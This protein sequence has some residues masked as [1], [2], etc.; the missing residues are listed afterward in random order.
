MQDQASA[1][2]V[3]RLGPRIALASLLLG[4]A[5]SLACAVLTIRYG[6]RWLTPMLLSLLLALGPAATLLVRC[7][8]RVMGILSEAPARR[9]RAPRSADGLLVPFALACDLGRV[10]GFEVLPVRALGGRC[11]RLALTRGASFLRGAV[12][13]RCRD[14]PFSPCVPAAFARS[15]ARATA[16][17]WHGPERLLVA[18][19]VLDPDAE[20]ARCEDAFEAALTW[21]ARA[22]ESRRRDLGLLGELEPCPVTA[23]ADLLLEAGYHRES[24]IPLIAASDTLTLCELEFAWPPGAR[25]ETEAVE[26][27]D[28]LRQRGFEGLHAAG[29]HAEDGPRAGDSLDL[30]LV[31]E[32]ETSLAVFLRRTVAGDSDDDHGPLAG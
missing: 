13:L 1:D 25:F 27:V 18:D 7:R 11:D 26:V 30:V 32:T 19:L 24:S 4:G 29:V 17:A 15:G 21:A 5:A 22:D 16:L 14:L 31:R 23:A 10:E 6:W 2:G 20:P 9:Y 3:A 8:V 28:S 12:R